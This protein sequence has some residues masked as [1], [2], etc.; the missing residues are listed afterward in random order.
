MPP[1]I[2]LLVFITKAFRTLA[3]P[4]SSGSGPGSTIPFIP[5]STSSDETRLSINTS[6]IDVP[7]GYSPTLPPLEIT[8]APPSQASQTVTITQAASTITVTADPDIVVTTVTGSQTRPPVDVPSPAA[9]S[10]GSQA[11]SASEDHPRPTE[12]VLPSQFTSIDE[13]FNIDHYAFGRENVQLSSGAQESENAFETHSDPG[14]DHTALQVSYPRGSYSPSHR[15]RGGTDFYATPSFYTSDE[16]M[17]LNPGSRENIPSLRDANNVTLSYSVF[18]PTTFDFVKGGKL[19]GLYGGHE[20]CSGGDDGLDC[21]S[22]RLMWRGGGKGELYLDQQPPALCSTPPRSVCDSAYGLS[23]GR[24]SFVFERGMWTHVSQTVWL[25]T[26]GLANGGFTLQVGSG[27]EPTSMNTVMS[28]AEVLYRVGEGSGGYFESESID[29]YFGEDDEPSDTTHGSFNEW[30][31][32]QNLL[33][34]ESVS[35]GTGAEPERMGGAQATVFIVEGTRTVTVPNYNTMTVTKT[36]EGT[37]T[38]SS[39]ISAFM[40]QLN[41]RSH[42]TVVDA[43]GPSPVGFIGIFFSYSTFFGGSTPDWASTKDQNAWFRDFK[44][45]ING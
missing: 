27:D 28:S 8:L 4:F 22:T 19:P 39:T 43:L 9:S 2:S 11:L 35:P 14:G 40:P 1:Y 32:V 42:S 5:T 38:P 30:N 7:P 12:W 13:A 3:V 29:D 23:I 34:S 16:N 44:L 18:F 20:K 6:V 15:P 10:S 36:L 37:A 33:S 41:G 17:D 45:V 26:P 24:G 31:P 25:N 21:F